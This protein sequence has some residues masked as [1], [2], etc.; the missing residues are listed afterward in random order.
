MQIKR[1]LCPI[2]FSEFSSMA[3]E[4]G[5]SLAEHYAAEFVILNVVELGKYPFADYAAYQVDFAKFSR[6]LEEGGAVRLREFVKNHPEQK[7]QPRLVVC[8]GNSS[9]SILAFARREKIELIVMGTHGRHGFN[10]VVLGSTA[11]RVMRTAEC[12]VLVV[13]KAPNQSDASAPQEPHVHH[14]RRILYCT[15]FSQNSERTLEYA[16]S[17]TAEYDAELTLLHVIEHVPRSF[18]KD[19]L[20][21]MCAE[22]LETLISPARR[23]SI[24]MNTAVRV[25]KSYEQIVQHSLENQIDMLVMAA[26]GGEALDRAVFGSTTYRVIQ[27][28]PCPVLAVHT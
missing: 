4:Y 1:I 20:I 15:D 19:E 22:R 16:I 7:I 3:Y 14:L 21:G 5:L 17:A 10:R 27:F 9:D 11:D 8:Q 12:P 23:D 18:G 25:G 6:A 13:S 26:R 28:A 2:D 24:K